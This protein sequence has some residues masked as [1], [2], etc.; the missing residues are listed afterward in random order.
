L[1]DL[2]ITQLL[3]SHFGLFGGQTLPPV[4][5][6]VEGFGGGQIYAGSG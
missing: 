4:A 1:P 3:R 6:V 2:G 5:D